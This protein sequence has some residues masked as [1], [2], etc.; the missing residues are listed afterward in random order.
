MH[1]LGASLEQECMNGI[2]ICALTRPETDV[3]QA[4]TPLHEPPISVRLG[5]PR[6]GGLAH[7]D[8]GRGL[9]F[10]H[11][12]SQ[13]PQPPINSDTS[14]TF[15]PDQKAKRFQSTATR[16][17]TDEKTRRGYNAAAAEL[18]RFSSDRPTTAGTTASAR[19]R[20]WA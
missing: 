10:V 4:A 19:V 16:E 15:S 8:P 6:D 13:S 18:G 7:P 5:C 17:T 20:Q 3:M 14:A 9:F 1:D 11:W 2:D 12:V